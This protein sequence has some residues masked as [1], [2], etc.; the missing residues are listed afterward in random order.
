[1]SARDLNFERNPKFFRWWLQSFLIDTQ[2]IVV[3]LRDDKGIVSR[4]VECNASEMYQE[5]TKRSSDRLCFN[6]LKGMLTLIS[7]FCAEDGHLYLA[8]RSFNS[9]FVAF[10]EIKRTSDAYKKNYFLRDWFIESIKSN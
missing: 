5:V 4:V 8:E 10:K 9:E 6:F 3:G 1:M 7:R 2:R